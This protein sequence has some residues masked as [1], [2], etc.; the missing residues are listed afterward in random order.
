TLTKTY[1]FLGMNGDTLPGGKTRSVP[2]LTSQDG[3]TSVADDNA[4]AGQPFETDTYTASG[5]SLNKAVVTVP[6]IIGPTAT[7]NRSGLP[8][9][10]AQMVRSAKSLTRQAVSYGW[11]KTEADTFYNT[12]LG[13]PT[14]GMP[15]QIDDRG[16]TADSDNVA[17]CTYTRY[18]SNTSPLLTLPAESITTAQD[19]S[20]AG[21]TPSG[22]LISDTRTS[23]DGHA[24]AY[25]GDGQQN[26]ALPDH[27]EATLVQKASSANGATGT[28]FV[29]ETATTY[30]SYGRTAKVTRTPHSTSPDG[31][32]LAQTISTSYSPSSGALPTST[33]TATQVTPGAA[34]TTSSTSSK[35]C[36]VATTTLD[37]ARNLPVAKTDE[38]N[39]L[40]SLTYDV[41]GRLTAVWL[42]NEAKASSAPANMT[43]TYDLS[44]NAPSVITENSLLDNGSYKS[45]ETLYDALLRSLQ[46]QDT[47]ENGTTTVSDT[48]YDSHGWTVA[49]N[50]AYNVSGNP[51]SK[52]VSVSQ[53]SIPD[54]TVTDY[55]GMGR[56]G[57]VTEEH[58][59]VKSWTTT[60]AYAGDKTTVLPPKG[61]VAT[62]TAVNARG[63]TTELDQYTSAPTLSGSAT[64]GFTATGGTPSAT[65]YTYFPAGQQHQVT[66]PDKAVWKFGYDLLGRKTSQTDPDAGETDY[67]FDDAGNLTSTQDARKTELD[68]TYDLLGRKLTG[69]DKSK[70][71]FQ[72]ASWTYD[73]LR[74]GK[75]TSSTRYVDGVTG[76]YTVASTGYT[77]LGKPTGTKITLPASEAPLP[78]TYTTTYT[79][80]TNDQLLKTQADPRTQGLNN[81]TITYDRDALGNPTKTGS[82][83]NTYV[84]ATVYTNFAEPSKVT[85]GASTNPA[86]A[87]YSYDDQTRRLTDRLI[88]RTQAPGPAVDDTKY[89]YDAS[90][91]PTSTTDQQ[92]ETGNT[93]T[94]QQC[95]SYDTLD[96]LTDAWTANDNCA[97][98]PPTS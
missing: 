27:G 32:S 97:A 69:T 64:S 55:D 35:D 88:E 79:Y 82:S 62:T 94:D 63:Q 54:T 22:T 19:C 15:V 34:C 30:D 78:S 49:T 25:D 45:S 11:R 28:A 20:S 8:D 46:T 56:A 18:L 80:T 93:V 44:Q 68:Y 40:T 81:E 41:L 70:S 39:L 87:T 58:D 31:K 2:D 95:Y 84:G 14:T 36:Q 37:P 59:G 33:V 76:G 12:T 24:F 53:V 48:Q 9:L 67:G 17:K 75:P 71:N 92:S 74:I 72:F 83:I 91:N 23:Y 16:E 98:N 3:A 21:A 4:L 51:G 50:N 42:P 47:A 85:F 6:T 77:T 57:L 29:D 61:G 43:F 10:T 38:A 96:R 73:T 26:P 52:L 13:K 89:A 66:G 60:T 90:G 86:W 65:T 5:G 1:Y 7:R